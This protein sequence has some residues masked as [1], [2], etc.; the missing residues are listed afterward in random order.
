MSKEK[1]QHQKTKTD[2][3]QTNEHGGILCYIYEIFALLWIALNEE[4]P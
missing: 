4:M 1:Q 2:E 3:K